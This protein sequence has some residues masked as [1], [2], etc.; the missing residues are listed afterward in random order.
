MTDQIPLC[1]VNALD[2]TGAFGITVQT[3]TGGFEV[4]LVKDPSASSNEPVVR[5]YRNACPHIA[6]PLETFDHEFIDKQNPALLVCSTHGAR[7]R[8]S[9]G[10]CISGPCKGTALI[11]LNIKIQNN[12][13]FLIPPK[14]SPLVEENAQQNGKET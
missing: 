2:H 14:S 5:A 4:L 10:H 8:I 1:Q 12:E 3:A 11:R 7:F 13:I 6:T 9:D